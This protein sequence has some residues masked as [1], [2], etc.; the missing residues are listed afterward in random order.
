MA[1]KTGTEALLSLI[2]KLCLDHQAYKFVATH[3][4]SEQGRQAVLLKEY[5]EANESRV[6][7][8]FDGMTLNPQNDP[9]GTPQYQPLIDAISK[10]LS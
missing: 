7:G 1:G 5:R 3:Y 6:F 4:C 10:A 2:Q 8:L 9:L